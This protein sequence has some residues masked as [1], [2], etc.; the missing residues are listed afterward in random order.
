MS[1]KNIIFN[2]KKIN[3]NKKLFMIDENDPNKILVSKKEPYAK[4]NHLNTPSGIVIMT[5]LDHLY[6]TSSNDWE[7]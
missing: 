2:K 7:C 3:K 1:E 5:T 4:K 6:K